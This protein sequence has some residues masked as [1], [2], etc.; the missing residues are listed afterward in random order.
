MSE[1]LL[2]LAA[3]K[4][5]TLTEAEQRLYRG[6]AEGKFPDFSSPVAAENDPATAAMGRRFAGRSIAFGRARGAQLRFSS[7]VDRG[8]AGLRATAH[9]SAP[10]GGRPC[11]IRVALG[12]GGP[13]RESQAAA[14]LAAALALGADPAGLE[15][16]LSVWRP[17]GALRQELR[18][19]A[20]GATAI[21]DAYNASPQSMAAALGFLALSA[22]AG[23]RAAVLGCM[24][25]LGDAA[26]S[27]HR[28]LGRRARAAGIGVL[29][30]LGEQAS[31]IV[32]GFGPGAR[33][34]DAADAAGAAA[35]IAPSLRA[36]TWCLFKGSRGLAIERVYQ[37]LQGA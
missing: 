6:V 3:E 16:R 25:E 30:A 4:F 19:L 26:P 31:E 29:A 5:G 18:A 17:A 36:G 1:R 33:A 9:W 11:R 13:A 35:W 27:L 32:R 34:F 12:Q 22:P 7:V 20:S 37:A 2:Q 21:L 14:A 15:R 24:L 10:L 23:R 8:A 28:A